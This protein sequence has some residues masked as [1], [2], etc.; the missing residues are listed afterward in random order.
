MFARNVTFQIKPNQGSAFASKFQKEVLPMLRKAPGF[1][2]EIT[3]L[4]NSNETVGITLWEN[5]EQLDAYTNNVDAQILKLLEPM[6]SGT[7][8]VRTYEVS[9]STAHKIPVA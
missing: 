1:R 4:R 7:P 5:R 8:D 6:T 2:D 3:L 9:S